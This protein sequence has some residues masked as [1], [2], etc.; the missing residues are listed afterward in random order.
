M[1]KRRYREYQVITEKF[2]FSFEDYREALTFYGKEK[3][4]ATLF[5]INNNCI[6]TLI[7]SK[8]RK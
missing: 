2:I 7:L 4:R 1:G 6:S 8:K 5:G 3:G